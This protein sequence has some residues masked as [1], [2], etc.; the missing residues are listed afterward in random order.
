MANGVE[1]GKGKDLWDSVKGVLPLVILL[2][3]GVL[4]WSDTQHAIAEGQRKAD[5]YRVVTEDR[6]KALEDRVKK[7]EDRTHE[8]QVEIAG[9]L[10]S[11]ETNIANLVRGMLNK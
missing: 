4:Q 2:A 1:N 3:S 10:G 9:R 8:I 11:M 6:F 5:A 7:S